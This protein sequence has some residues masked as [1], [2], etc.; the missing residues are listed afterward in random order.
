MSFR[1]RI[2]KA[3]LG[4]ARSGAFPGVRRGFCQVPPKQA[5]LDRQVPHLPAE[6]SKT[7]KLW[8]L[9]KEVAV[10]TWQGL[11]DAGSDIAFVFRRV[12]SKEAQNLHDRIRM[13]SSKTNLLKFLPFSFFVI[14]PFSEVLLPPYMYLF[15]NATPSYFHTSS[16]R[17][18][19]TKLLLRKQINAWRLLNQT[20]RN[21]STFDMAKLDRLLEDLANKVPGAV[22]RVPE[23]DEEFVEHVRS[24]FE[25]YDKHMSPENMTNDEIKLVLDMFRWHYISG[26]RTLGLLMNIDLILLNILCKITFR[27]TYPLRVYEFDFFPFGW[28]SRRLLLSQLKREW[29]SE[30]ATDQL[31]KL[32][33]EEQ[34]AF[35]TEDDLLTLSR[36]RCFLQSSVAD[37]IEYYKHFWL[38]NLDLSPNQNLWIQIMRGNYHD[39]ILGDPE[40][41]KKTH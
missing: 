14:I 5:E 11:K 29:K 10:H 36:N 6:P 17:D 4:A 32:N 9:I 2:L 8:K 30:Q 38:P 16:S 39:H 24:N 20:L 31:I 7:K 25:L 12:T 40:K 37:V 23:F 13:R 3:S 33:P 41:R 35:A 15:P 27:A 28:I 1:V 21:N 18:A 19:T 22:E 34:I 26:L